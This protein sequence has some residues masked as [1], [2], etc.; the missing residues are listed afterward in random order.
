[1]AKSPTL[2]PGEFTLETAR[3]AYPVPSDPPPALIV[4]STGTLTTPVP[5][6]STLTLRRK[7]WDN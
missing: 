5:L 7:R 3:L 6:L 2:V 4:E 1:L